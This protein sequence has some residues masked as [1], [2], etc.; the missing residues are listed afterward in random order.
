MGAAKH[1]QGL[2]FLLK[3]VYGG[4]RCTILRF[5][6]PRTPGIFVKPAQQ[7]RWIAQTVLCVYT[8]TPSVTP[9]TLPPQFF[10]QMCAQTQAQTPASPAK[11]LYTCKGVVYM[12]R[13]CI[14]AKVLYACK[15][16]VY[17]QRCCI[18]AK[19]CERRNC[20][21]GIC[22]PIAIGL[23]F[24]YLHT[25]VQTALVLSHCKSW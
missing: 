21:C 12:Q 10:P 7:V 16:V 20:L 3:G 11:L 24:A 22:N 18:H 25:P 13:C 8:F 5:W 14:H 6:P 23:P 19:V 1:T 4:H 17:I 2:T 15:G 9:L